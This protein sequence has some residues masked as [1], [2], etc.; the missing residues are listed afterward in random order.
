MRWGRG[1]RHGLKVLELIADDTGQGELR[2]MVCTVSECVWK[3]VLYRNRCE[4]RR[5]EGRGEGLEVYLQR[6]L[7]SKR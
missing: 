6:D 2:F 3:C 4:E 7:Q 1:E 5:R